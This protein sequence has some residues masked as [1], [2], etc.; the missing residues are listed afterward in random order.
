MSKN[1]GDIMEQ[2]L[3]EHN[4]PKDVQVEFFIQI[5]KNFVFKVGLCIVF[6]FPPMYNNLFRQRILTICLQYIQEN[7]K[8]RKVRKLAEIA[9]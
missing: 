2:I 8:N 6:H 9:K 3:T 5:V 7:Y 4:V 1:P